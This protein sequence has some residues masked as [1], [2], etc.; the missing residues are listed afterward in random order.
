MLEVRALSAAYGA[1]PALNE[2]SLSVAA[3]EIVVILGANGAGKSTLLRAIAGICEGQVSGAVTLGGTP[4]AGLGSDEIVE[5][6]VALVPE[7]RGIFGDLTVRENLLL[8]AYSKRARA[9]EGSNLDRVMR[10]FPKLRERQGQIART[11]SGGEQQMV[12]IG[13]AMM[14]APQILMLDEPSLG[15]SPLL[16]KE[17]FQNLSLVRELGIGVLLVEQNAKQSLAI[18]DRGYLLENTQITHEDSAARLATDAAVQKAYLG[19]SGKAAAPKHTPKTPVK[20]DDAPP[21]KPPTAS[22][23]RPSQDYG[24]SV[25]DMVATAATVSAQAPRT[26]APETAAAASKLAQDRVQVVLRDIEAAAQAARARVS[27]AATDTDATPTQD[28]PPSFTAKPPVIEVYRRPRV[29]VFRRRPSGQFER[30]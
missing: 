15:L 29:E 9:D 14:S 1:H 17:L 25:D 19:G 12:A 23:N 30:D 7:G 24:F 11:M 3:G 18:A 6:G 4:L 5:R 28:R 20:A 26:A 22:L 10:L 16:C 27:R 13:R 21:P 8:G 2:V